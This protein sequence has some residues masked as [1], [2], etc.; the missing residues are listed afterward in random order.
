MRIGMSGCEPQ[1]L[2]G[3]PVRLESSSRNEPLHDQTAPDLPQSRHYSLTQNL[4]DLVTWQ[5]RVF[6][7]LL[8]RW[9]TAGM[10]LEN[11]SNKFR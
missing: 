5:G 9:R 10:L 4:W 11:H 7:L 2:Q 3:R 1:A 6:V 8:A